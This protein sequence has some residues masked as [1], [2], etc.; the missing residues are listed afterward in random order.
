[1]VEISGPGQ[2]AGFGS[3]LA[4]VHSYPGRALAVIRSTEE[5]DEITV[6]GK[7]VSGLEKMVSIQ[8]I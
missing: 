1:M 6:K 5:S 4:K 3:T 7:T 2:L 8:A